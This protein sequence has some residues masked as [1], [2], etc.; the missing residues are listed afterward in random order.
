MYIGI[1]KLDK[2]V[3]FSSCENCTTCCDGTK[4]SLA[5]LIMDDFK[6]VY[7]Y[8]SILF[9]YIDGNLKAL[10]V[11]QENQKCKYLENGRCS[12]YHER[13]PVCQ[14]YPLSPLYEDIFIDNECKAINDECC[15]II[16]KNGFYSSDFYH[17]RVDNFIHKLDDTTRFLDDIKDN[18]VYY[19]QVSGI[20]LFKIENYTQNEFID[21]HHKSLNI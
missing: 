8:F 9:G 19:K 3:Y 5:P 17:I 18:L 14:M 21:F 1:N 6:L 16:T 10:I 7:K 11:M 13:P 15:T 2:E 12:I 4:F 20:D